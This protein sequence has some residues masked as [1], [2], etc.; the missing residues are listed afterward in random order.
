MSQHLHV[1]FRRNGIDEH[2]ANRRLLELRQ[3]GLSH[4]DIARVVT[5]Y[6]GWP[7][8]ESQVRR[9]LRVLGVRGQPP[10]KHRGRVAA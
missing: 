10:V 8:S 6:E 4:D 9:R 3:L 7:L 5:Y 1:F 2:R